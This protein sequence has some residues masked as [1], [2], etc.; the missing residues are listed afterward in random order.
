MEF[1]VDFNKENQPKEVFESIGAK[2][3]EVRTDRWD[4]CSYYSIEINSLEELK[5]LQSK[6]NKKMKTSAWTY[7]M[8]IDMSENSLPTIYFDRDI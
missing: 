7:S 2:L 4:R 6:V 1:E 5:E 8:V 3:K